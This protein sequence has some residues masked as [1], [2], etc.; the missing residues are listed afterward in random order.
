[1]ALTT[2]L[3][4]HARNFNQTISQQTTQIDDSLMQGISS[5]RRTSENITRQSLKAIEGLAGQ[6][7][8]LRNV[9]ENLL[10]QINTV[11]G[12]FENQG[13]AIMRAANSLETI[14]YKIDQTLQQRHAELS[15]R[16]TACPARPTS[17]AASSKATLTTID[18]SLTDAEARARAVAHEIIL[19]AEKTK[20]AALADL[21]RFRSEADA[22]GERALDDLRRRFSSVSNAVS[23]ELD[24]L[25]NRFDATTEEVRQRTHKAHNEIA[26]EQAWLREQ[27]DRLPAATRESA[28][29]M[30]RA[31]QDQMRALEQLSSLTSRTAQSRDVAPPLA[32]PPARPAHG[33]IGD[34]R[35]PEPVHPDRLAPRPSA[36]PLGDPMPRALSPPRTSPPPQRATLPPP[37]APLQRPSSA[38]DIQG[39]SLGD[40]LARAS[41]DEDHS[42]SPANLPVSLPVT[43]PVPAPA[44]SSPPGGYQLNIDTIA[45]ALDPATT[46]AIWT[47]IRGGQRGIMVRSIYS[48]E[49]R[50]AFDEVSRR[51]KT[52]AELARTVDRYLSDFERIQQEAESKD[53]SGRLVQNHLTSDTGRVYLFLAHASGRLS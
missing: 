40:L 35:A 38:A 26:A 20:R 41:K 9:S 32:L 8:V 51:V 46:N 25:S 17:S 18:G 3:D 50:A 23:E 22:Q 37:G 42:S 21:E 43:A 16:S 19:G 53:P 49:G 33:Q 15:R 4:A 52:D 24:T 1:M 29:A 7:E 48:Q 2:A 39:W 47:R 45:R 11:T 5:V 12:R 34:A 14:N 27:M 36:P 13:Q 10:G 30:R 6:S 28:D 44:P 31:L